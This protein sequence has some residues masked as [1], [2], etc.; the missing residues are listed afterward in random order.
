MLQ[1]QV[2]FHYR[3]LW[4]IFWVY[5]LCFGSSEIESFFLPLALLADMTLRPLKVDILSLNPC[6]FFLLRREG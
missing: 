5:F 3:L 4:Y 6:L 1:E 2:R